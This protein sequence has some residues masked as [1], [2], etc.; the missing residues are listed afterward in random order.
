MR[1]SECGNAAS[2]RTPSRSPLDALADDAT[3]VATVEGF[4]ARNPRRTDRIATYE[5]LLSSGEH[6]RLA[7][8]VLGCCYRPAPPTEGWL[9]KLDGRKKRIFRYDPADE[10]LLRTVNRLVQD[11]AMA[12]ASP[13]CRSFLPGGG[14][15]AAFRHVRAD[16]HVAAHGALRLD[17]R[18]YFNSIDVEHLLVSLPASFRSGP[19]GAL[20]HASLLDRRVRAGGLVVDGGRKGVMAGTPIAP[21][22]ATLYLRDLDAEVA[23]SGA[24]YA[25]Y[26]DDVLVLAPPSELP[27]LERL[28]RGRLAERGLEI[29]ESKTAVA[30]P[31][32]PWDFLGFRYHGGDVGLAPVTERKARAR[33]TRLARGLV[34]WRERTGAEPAHA[35][36]AFLRRTNRRLYGVPT[37]R[38]DFSWGTWFLPML[39]RTDGLERLDAHLQ[40]EARFAATGRRTARTRRT[41][42][43]DSMVDAGLLPLRAAYWTFQSGAAEY[44]ALVARRTGLSPAAATA[45]PR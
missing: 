13:W 29:N 22:L 42:P 14:A 18:D 38:A 15:R 12:E 35:L 45:P 28:V 16:R 33:A 39:D 43:Y 7:D 6:H 44:E 37:E 31:G 5:Q 8:D 19:L 30:G 3:W 10:L 41:V 36:R 27:D 32:E 20:L 34:R 11:D 4:R 2:K 40:R 1:T 21:V 24:T 25:R 23:S 17:V 26:S 9:N